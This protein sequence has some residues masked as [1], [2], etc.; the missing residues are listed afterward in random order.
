MPIP[1]LLWKI[2]LKHKATVPFLVVF[3]C[4]IFYGARGMWL[5]ETQQSL[6]RQIAPAVTAAPVEQPGSLSVLD[7]QNRSVALVLWGRPRALRE[8]L[9]R[10]RAFV[11]D[12]YKAD[13]FAALDSV[14]GTDVLI[15]QFGA[16]VKGASLHRQPS[17]KEIVTEFMSFPN[18]QK[19]LDKC[20]G[21]GGGCQNSL[22]PAKGTEG[23][24]LW[25]YYWLNVGL[26]LVETHERKRG[27][28]YD[29]LIASRTDNFFEHPLPPI[30]LLQP[31][32]Y[33]SPA[34]EQ[35]G[36][37]NQR[38]GIMS[39][40]VSDIFFGIWR[41]LRTGLLISKYGRNDEVPYN[42]EM[43]TSRWLS[44]MKVQF[45]FFMSPSWTHCPSSHASECTP[46]TPCVVSAYTCYHR[47][48]KYGSDFWTAITWRSPDASWKQSR[49]HDGKVYLEQD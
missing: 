31:D 22:S 30:R 48:W 45:A 25:Q 27:F 21:W 17:R 16:A 41:A 9:P 15:S 20:T 2:S 36:G 18:A 38:I 14:P 3:L 49:T 23:G 8:C 35:H 28:K 29:W 37:V 24:S 47:R 34:Q 43:F 19:L 12:Y 40:N 42:T 1:S 4:G 39:R 6:T 11:V 26:E 46:E 7:P 10:I 32:H 44:L 5:R 33:F 13:V